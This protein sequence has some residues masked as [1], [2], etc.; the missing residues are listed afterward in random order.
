[1]TLA[2]CFRDYPITRELVGVVGLPYAWGAGNL[3]D[4]QR[5][6]PVDPSTWPKS[7]KGQGGDC[8][9]LAQ[10]VLLRMGMINENSWASF[11]DWKDATAHAL[12]MNAFDAIDPKDAR[13]GD[14]YF[15]QGN[16][17]K[18]YH[19]TPALGYGLCIHASSGSGARNVHGQHPE[20]AAQ[21]VHYLR[22][23]PFKVAG[24]LKPHLN[25]LLKR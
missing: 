25:E 1:M 15:Y 20:R 12:A 10:W 3:V 21:A 4:L 8:S 13:P 19:V 7:E 6:D 5:M 22:A 2:R 9:A 24:R 16:A 18:I 17:R 11:S 23:G 14:M